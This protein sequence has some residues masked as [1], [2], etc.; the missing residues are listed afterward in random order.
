MVCTLCDKII[1]SCTTLGIY[2]VFFLKMA[3]NEM[4]SYL[5]G[6]I[7]AAGVVLDFNPMRKGY[8]SLT[9][10]IIFC[11]ALD[12]QIRASS[13]SFD[14][15]RTVFQPINAGVGMRKI[16]VYN[17]W[18]HLLQIF[19]LIIIE[20]IKILSG[21]YCV[22]ILVIE[23]KTNVYVN[24]CLFSLLFLESLLGMLIYIVISF[25]TLVR[26][27]FYLEWIRWM[28]RWYLCDSVKCIVTCDNPRVIL[29]FEELEKV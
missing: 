25:F 6:L 16:I 9:L 20:L 12:K 29:E 18:K 4:I 26:H 7:V 28:A 11:L 14:M 21:V 27:N 19:F 3:L 24:Y 1:F 15:I 13:K 2:S 22:I 10:V 5:L 17:K 23:V 8:I